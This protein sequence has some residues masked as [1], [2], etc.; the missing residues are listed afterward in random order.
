MQY[1]MNLNC[2][3]MAYTHKK[4]LTNWRQHCQC[5][6]I[7]HSTYILENIRKTTLGTGTYSAKQPAGS[8]WFHQPTPRASGAAVHPR[9]K[10]QRCK[11]L[12]RGWGGS[13]GCQHD[14]S[15]LFSA[16]LWLVPSNCMFSLIF[17]FF[18]LFHLHLISVYVH[19]ILNNIENITFWDL[20][21]PFLLVKS[22]QIPL[23]APGQWLPL[24]FKCLPGS[25]E[26]RPC[27]MSPYHY[28]LDARFEKI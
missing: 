8:L 28:R 23:P 4:H 10:P 6:A 12:G 2:S 5:N 27:F 19:R 16:N 17:L 9:P 18:C 14:V 3:S 1:T 7:T 11:C 24:D 21:P 25:L 20:Y 22:C 15:S 13:R 26:R